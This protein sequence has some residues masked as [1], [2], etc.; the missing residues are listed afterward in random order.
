LLAVAIL[1]LGQSM[2]YTVLSI[3]AMMLAMCS[4]SHSQAA[5]QTE[6]SGRQG[7]PVSSASHILN[8]LQPLGHHLALGEHTCPIG[9]ERFS[10]LTLGT[11][12]T[13][14]R[15][16]DLKP[17]SYMDFPAPALVC[18]ANGFVI[19]KKSYGEEELKKYKTVIESE[20]Y[21]SIYQVQ[22]PS[23]YLRAKFHELSGED[24]GNRW[25]DLLQATWEADTCLSERYSFYADEA[26]KAAEAAVEAL[27]SDNGQYWAMH[28]MISDLYRRTGRFDLAQQRL[29]RISGLAPSDPK[30]KENF[31]PFIALQQ[32]AI[33]EKQTTRVDVERARRRK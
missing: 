22:H 9:G 7:P 14:G 23:Y 28:I 4:L 26:I 15:H 3:L 31:A 20:A 19:A 32:A 1:L 29:D 18:P 27:S 12:S 8:C 33:N 25:W 11:H 6:Q 30:I 17:V 13:F 16:L 10:S 2:K 21:K 24:A 5:A